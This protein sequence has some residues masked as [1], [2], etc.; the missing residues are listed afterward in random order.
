MDFTREPIIETIIT[1]KDGCKLVIRNSKAVGQEEYFVDAVEVVSFGHALFFRSLERPKAFLV[2]VSDYEVLEVRETRMV[3]KNVGLERA[4]KIGGGREGSLKASREEKAEVIEQLVESPVE[5]ESQSSETTAATSDAKPEVRLDKK[6]ER[7]RHYRKRKGG[8]EEQASKEEATVEPGI[9]S[10]EEGGKV[11]IPPP[12]EG[13]EASNSLASTPLAT[14]VF[15]SL[16]QP[17]PQLISETINRYRENALF[18][19]AFFLPEEEYKPHGKVTELLNEDEELSSENQYKGENEEGLTQEELTSNLEQLEENLQPAE[20][21][22]KE[23]EVSSEIP[24]AESELPSESSQPTEELSK[25]EELTSWLVE[26]FSQEEE[27]E[28]SLPL[29]ADEA[30][31]EVEEGEGEEPKTEPSS[32]NAKHEEDLSF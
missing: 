1:P 8:R 13:A 6:R 12:E 15:S 21:L 10:L 31:V 26:E 5:A 29:Y 20:E 28:G 24:F 11:D 30:E 22:F 27:S 18:K 23:E 2:P 16:L 32:S 25:E 14:N 19:S 7:R 3:L 9:T 17:P 4:I